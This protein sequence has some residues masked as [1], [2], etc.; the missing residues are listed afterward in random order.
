MAV[1]SRVS[2]GLGR[3]RRRAAASVG[4]RRVRSRRV[5]FYRALVPKDSVCFDVGANIGNRVEV[6]LALGAAVVA[7]EPQTECAKELDR[8]FGRNA[9]FTLVKTAVGPNHG[10]ATLRIPAA[11]TIATLSPEFVSATQRSGRF[12]EFSWDREVQ[13]PVTTL[14]ALVARYGAPAFCKI[15][16]EGYEAEVLGGLSRALRCISFE[17]TAEIIGVAF[18]CIDHLTS[19][20][21]YR[22]NISRGETMEW[23]LGEWV[24]PAEMRYRLSIERYPN[25][26]DVYAEMIE[27]T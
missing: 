8:R 18:R 11:S 23:V 1:F 20:G 27:S 7:I 5:A 15:D 3:V 14:D 17:Y 24:G 12:S 13:V 9:R 4:A 21:Q 25:W 26:G 6:F 16:V 10:V 2:R 19:L 22:Y